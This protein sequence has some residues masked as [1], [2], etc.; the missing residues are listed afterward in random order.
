MEIRALKLSCLF[1]H[2]GGEKKKSPT[3]EQTSL[4]EWEGLGKHSY[5]YR[6][7]QKTMNPLNTQRIHL[8][9]G[10]QSTPRDEPD[11]AEVLG[12]GETPGGHGRA[13][14][15]D[16]QPTSF[17]EQRWRTTGAGSRGGCTPASPGAAGQLGLSPLFLTLRWTLNP[18]ST[19]RISGTRHGSALKQS[20][21]RGYA[22]WPRTALRCQERRLP[23][24]AVP[25]TQV[26]LT[27]GPA[28]GDEILLRLC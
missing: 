17:G 8:L 19:R 10:E 22:A 9:P 23:D 14:Q 6:G 15:K 21:T 4:R 5:S 1:A 11:A 3:V 20:D 13:R 2:R 12:R 16:A 25:T 27:L 18:P 26:A 28:N 7:R 24:P